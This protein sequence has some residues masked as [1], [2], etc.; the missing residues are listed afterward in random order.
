MALGFERSGDAL[1]SPLAL[2]ALA[3]DLWN[4]WPAFALIV[5]PVRKGE[6]YQLFAVGQVDIPHLGHNADAHASA[7]TKAMNR[8]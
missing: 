6:R 2:A 7:S 5:A 4:R 8:G 3:G 1:N